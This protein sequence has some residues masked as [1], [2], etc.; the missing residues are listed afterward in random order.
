[1][2]ID[3][4]TPTQEAWCL[5]ATA[6]QIANKV[7]DSTIPVALLEE[8]ATRKPIFSAKLRELKTLMASMPNPKE[9]AEYKAVMD[10]VASDPF[11]EETGR[12]LAK[13]KSYRS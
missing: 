7:N 8:L 12:R 1:M 5:R 6:A 10:L 2:P 11:G 4:L 9:E 3:K 13:Y